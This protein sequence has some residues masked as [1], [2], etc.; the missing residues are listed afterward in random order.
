MVATYGVEN[1]NEY[2]LQENKTI[3][4]IVKA[5][6][7]VKLPESEPTCHTGLAIN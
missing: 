5:T 4:R 1:K 2:F 7:L 3:T 6:F